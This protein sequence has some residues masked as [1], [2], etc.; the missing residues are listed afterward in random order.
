MLGAKRDS[1]EKCGSYNG[2]VLV[3]AIMT[4]IQGKEAWSLDTQNRVEQF[5]FCGTKC[6]QDYFGKKFTKN[7]PRFQ[8]LESNM[9]IIS[10]EKLER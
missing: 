2:T 5:K 8:T 10:M 1:C 7:L 4:S 6:V 3:L 9:A